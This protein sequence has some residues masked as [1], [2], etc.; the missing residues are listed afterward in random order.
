MSYLAER[1]LIRD[2]S[3]TH[4]LGNRLVLIAG[5]D[6]TARITIGPGLS[7]GALVADGRLA[8]ADVEAVPAGKYARAALETL[9]AWPDVAERLAQSENVRAA[10]KLVATGEA[11]LGIVYR[12]DAIAEPA[13]KILGT[14]PE[15]SHP[16]IIYPMA[17]TIGSTNPDAASLF[18]YLRS[19]K[20]KSIFEAHGFRFLVPQVSN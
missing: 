6:A 3:V 20:A 10:L 4:L 9:G 5:K 14:F 7:L 2:D 18:E 19:A 13:V 17:L 11:P 16:P 12:T 8:V 1:E 15:F